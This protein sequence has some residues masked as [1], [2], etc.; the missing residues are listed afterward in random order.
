[1]QPAPVRSENPTLNLRRILVVDNSASARKL[2]AAALNDEN[3]CQV[4][5]AANCTEALTLLHAHPDLD[6]IVCDLSLDREDG[7]DFIGRLRADGV[8]IPILVTTVARTFDSMARAM[9]AGADDY[10]QKP[11]DLAEL[12]RALAVLLSYRGDARK[13][14]PPYTR[15]SVI[16]RTLDDGCS[17][18]LTA[19]TH[20][21]QIE[22]FQ[23]FAERMSSPSLS[24][25][26]RVNLRLALEEIVQNA[27]E[28]GNRFDAG[29]MVRLSCCMLNDRI[30]I[31][32]E[33]EG[34]GFNPQAVPD[35][36]AN[37][38]EH[39]KQRVKS[40]KRIGGW[41]L[42][43]TRKLMDEVVFNDKGN[44]VC[45]T[46]RFP[47]AA[48]PEPAPSPA[49]PPANETRRFKKGP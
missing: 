24:E 6:A 2:V 20:S 33:D 5:P 9:E 42:F 27:R 41:G 31:R 49:S 35:P 22:S 8:T 21:A 25:T 39:V 14:R 38:K 36:S 30:V 32:V 16:H 43:L 1:M 13:P 26:D 4:F 46:K 37:P 10:L 34:P 19:P 48:A 23:R 12:R 18:E 45:I 44:V 7:A 47:P 15:A 28:W 17:F 29:K 40:G 3:E 11:L